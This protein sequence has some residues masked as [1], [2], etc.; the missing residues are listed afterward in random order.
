MYENDS[1]INEIHENL[2][3]ETEESFAIIMDILKNHQPLELIEY[4]SIIS[5]FYN[6]IKGNN[7]LTASQMEFICGI[8][9]SIRYDVGSNY[10]EISHEVIQSL[11]DNVKKFFVGFSFTTY[12][13]KLLNANDDKERKSS[14]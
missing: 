6:D 13:R 5:Y 1:I 2:S 12:T 11:L 14:F 3:K 8:M 7:F 4:L 10:N 9:L